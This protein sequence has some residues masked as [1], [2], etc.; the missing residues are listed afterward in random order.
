MSGGQR[1][2]I[3]IA[4]SIISNP[5]ILL[6]DEATS[7]LDPKAE[8]IV[9]EALDKVSANRT[10]LVIAHKLATVQKADNIA[11]ISN[12]KVVEQGTHGKLLAANGHYARLVAAQDL[13]R[14]DEGEVR[15][16]TSKIEMT[17]QSSGVAPEVL[18]AI[19]AGPADRERM[20]YSLV[21]CLWIM[22]A[23]QRSIYGYLAISA[24]ACVMAGGTYPSQA[25]VFSRVLNVF[26]LPLA[27]GHTKA[28]FWSLMFFVIALGN[29][30]AYAIIG[31]MCM[32]ISFEVTHFY[33]RQMFE[34]ILRQDM[35]FF[36]QQHNTSG[37]LSATLSMVPTRLQELIGVNLLLIVIL[38]V[39]IVSSSVLALA[40]GW[41]LGLVVVFGGLTLLVLSGYARI[42]VE[43]A[44]TDKTSK[45]F[46]DSAG[47]ASEAVIAIKTVASLKLEPLLMD[48]YRKMLGL[49]VRSESK[50][51]VL[52]LILYAASQSLENL[53]IALGFWYGGRLVSTG[54]YTITQFYVIFIG[55]L[56]AGQA[57]GQFFSYSTSKHR[58]SA[59]ILGH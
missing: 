44:L 48:R 56:F 58:D 18:A 38:I 12:G 34:T 54:E 27:Q 42:R 3:A 51:L 52:L 8:R 37:A 15:S 59:G 40:Y 50:W 7:A 39:N 21:K 29:L 19:A 31:A 45:A 20:E 26:T 6:L 55:V 24:I 14:Q 30:V 11:V 17:R 2:R 13:N 35:S 49:I 4:R 5:K 41:K 57:A 53:A 9:Q 25:I 1:Q 32:Y 46:S 10:T 33:R 43:T 22:L 16:K 36:D 23:E 28:D 47:V